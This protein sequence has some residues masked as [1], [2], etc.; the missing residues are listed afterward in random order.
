VLKTPLLSVSGKLRL[1]WEYFTPR[2]TEEGDESL[3]SFVCRRLG[4][5]AY[6][7]LVQPL[8]GGIYTADPE[9]L[10]MAAAMPQFVA[11]EREY[12]GLIRGVRRGAKR[13]TSAADGQESGA[14]YGLFVAPRDGMTSFV[15]AIA[16]RLPAGCV[17]LQRRVE[18][19]S[20]EPR[21]WQ[22]SIA[23]QA[24]PRSF[25]GVIVALR[26]PQAAAL[27][28]ETDAALA[29]ELARIEYAGAAVVVCAYSREQIDHPLDGFGFVVPL[30]EKRQILAGSFSSNKFAGRA[31]E[32][33]V[34]MR[35]FVGGAC[36]PELLERDDDELRRIVAD[37]LREL[38][39]ARGEPRFAEVVRWN[40]AMPQYHVGHLDLVARIEAAA[41][42]HA[43]L[44]LAGNAYRGVGIPFCIHSGQ[45][46]AQRL[47]TGR[48]TC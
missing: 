24:E 40:G 14:R 27:L 36:Q 23:G 16:A 30:A 8:I 7:R 4:R 12:G 25:D 42:R 21:G 48:E 3:K 22:L 5:E 32:G 11:L 15:Q 31:P 17:E 19:L 13:R 43:S 33:Q 9:K 18:R 2:R 10:S 1:A 46:A 44:E 6:E 28:R 29:D 35:I 38:I 26:A 41:A 45:Q 20:R 37:E 34:L 39:G 47:C